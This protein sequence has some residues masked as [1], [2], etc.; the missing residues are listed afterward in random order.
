MVRDIKLETRD[1]ADNYIKGEPFYKC[2]NCL[3]CYKELEEVQKHVLFRHIETHDDQ[4]CCIDELS[5]EERNRTFEYYTVVGHHY[6]CT[7]CD[8]IGHTVHQMK[9]HTHKQHVWPRIKHD[10]E[11]SQ[12]WLEFKAAPFNWDGVTV[13]VPD[14]R[15]RRIEQLE[16]QNRDLLKENTELN[17]ELE[18]S[19]DQNVYNSVKV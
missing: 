7:E 10:A 5:E 1:Y 12:D 17:T 8:F 13:P 18:E 16:K 11:L 15:D 2:N 19:R 3:D 4:T 14:L 6:A 9:T